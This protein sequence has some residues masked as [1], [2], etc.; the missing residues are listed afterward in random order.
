M[1]AKTRKDKLHKGIFRTL[2]FTDRA[3]FVLSGIVVAG[4]VF[5]LFALIVGHIYW[6]WYGVVTLFAEAL[7]YMVAILHVERQPIYKILY[8]AIFYSFSPTKMRSS[9]I[10]QYFTNFSIQDNLIFRR[11]SIPFVFRFTPHEISG[12]AE[13][14]KQLFFS[15]VTTSLNML[16][17]QLQ[18]IVRKE[19]ATKGDLI[20]HFLFL[21]GNISKG[22]TRREEMLRNYRQDL[23]DFVE[24]NKLLMWKFYGV[25]SVPA[26]TNNPQDKLK[27]IGKLHDL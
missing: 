7:F 4:I 23:I 12:L 11:H 2:L 22:D 3:L 16:T 9:K 6:I 8:R 25:F 14:K 20:D 24:G 19:F 18:I 15:Q 5:V 26:N 10:G 21:G 27:G 13:N 17:T 1:I